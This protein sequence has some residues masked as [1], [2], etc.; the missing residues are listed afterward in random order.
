MQIGPSTTIDVRLEAVLERGGV[1]VGLE[2]GARLAHRIGGAVELAGAVVAAADHGAHRAV[3]VHKYGGGLAGVIFAAVL[4]QRIFHRVLGRMLH[5]GVERRAHHEDAFG[6]R[7]RE[8]IDELL[9]VV[10]GP[11]EII[12]G[13]AVVAPVDGGCRIA[14]GAEHLA[15]GHEAGVHQI[16]EH[17]VGARARGRQVDVGRILGRRLEQAGQHRGFRQIDVA[18]R[19]VEII[20][21][22]GIDAEGAAAHIGAVEI[23]FEDLV[24]GQPRF[25]PHR[26]ERFLDLAL[27]RALIIEKQIFGELLGD[28]G[29][30]LHDAAGARVGRQRAEN[31]G[32]VDAEMLV[33]APVLGGE[34]GLDQIVGKLVERHGIVM[35]D[36]AR[37]DLVAVAVEEGHRQFRFLQPVVV[38]CFV[39]R[40]QRQR[41]RQHR[42]GGR[43][44]LRLPRRTR[45][46]RGGSPTTWK[47]SMKVE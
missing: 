28:G 33:E 19:L 47:R 10:E 46:A 42:A 18:R 16:V 22:R 35:P 20:L 37:A 26:Q 30:A 44:T 3:H 39:K 45:P 32:H 40:R 7:F 38:G 43:L 31:A 17:D 8:G 24:L 34:H 9:H 5:I 1:D 29:A 13:R 41:Q 2:R 25:Q 14:A 12:V 23:K 27:K 11:I 21:C 36:A 15:F 4:A 6:H